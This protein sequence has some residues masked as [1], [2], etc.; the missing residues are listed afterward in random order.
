MIQRIV[1]VSLIS[2]TEGLV[3]QRLVHASLISATGVVPYYLYTIQF[4]N[5]QHISDYLPYQIH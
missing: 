1:H 5:K 2:V 3:I 4:S